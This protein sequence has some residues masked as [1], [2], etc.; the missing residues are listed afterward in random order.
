MREIKFR[1]W[2]GNK[3]I[4]DWVR[5]DYKAS[6]LFDGIKLPQNHTISCAMNINAVEIMQ[7][8]DKTDKNGVEIYEGDIT[9]LN[10]DIHTIGFQDGCFLM[11]EETEFNG[12][13]EPLYKY[14]FEEY[15][16]TDL[17]II[18]NVYENPELLKE[19]E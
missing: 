6:F 4:Y 16:G 1:A 3:I 9:S 12:E 5:V 14:F 10:G 15:E 7:Y 8:T 13:I 17:V 18:G 2:D 19:Q 11:I